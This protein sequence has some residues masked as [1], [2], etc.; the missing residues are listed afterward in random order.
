MLGERR[1]VEDVGGVGKEGG[2]DVRSACLST[3]VLMLV[4]HSRKRAWAER[5][6]V[7]EVV[8]CSSS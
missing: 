2:V 7:Y 8:R 4:M 6:R 5:R 1:E 3:P